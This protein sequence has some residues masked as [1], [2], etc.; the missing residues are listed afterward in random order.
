MAILM[1]SLL[2]MLFG[3]S[4]ASAIP[5]CISVHGGSGIWGLLAAGFFLRAKDASSS[6]NGQL[7]FGILQVVF[8]SASVLQGISFVR[9]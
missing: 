4:Y 8:S 6:I 9:Y 5:G 7:N 3:F 1:P 2:N